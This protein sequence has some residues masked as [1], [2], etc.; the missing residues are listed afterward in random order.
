MTTNYT[1]I[2]LYGVEQSEVVAWC[3]AN[4]IT[5]YVSPTVDDTTVLYENTLQENRHL[6]QPL[7]VLLARTAQVAADLMCAAMVAVVA[8]DNMFMYVLFVDGEMQD[9]YMSYVDKKPANGK[10][11]I[12]A[13]TF[14]A[15]NEIARIRSALYREAFTSATE[16][17]LELMDALVL[18]PLM[19]DIGFEYLE[20]GEKPHGVEDNND[21]IYTGPDD[22]LGS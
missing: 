9:N 18:P 17:H 7:E 11:E 5:A 20:E 4:H 19:I 13:E 10:P 16:R 2:T 8:E 22:D 3:E 12:L 14:D 6:S 15:A 21:V 1:N